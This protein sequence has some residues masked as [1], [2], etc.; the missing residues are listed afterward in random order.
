MLERGAGDRA[1]FRNQGS[2]RIFQGGVRTLDRFKQQ[3]R[4]V[5][6]ENRRTL[7]R[8]MVDNFAT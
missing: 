6:D 5:R 4:W 7:D 3:Y 8:T 1:V 2:Y